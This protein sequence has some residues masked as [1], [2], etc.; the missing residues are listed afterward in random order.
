MGA[1]GLTSLGLD[2][3]DGFDLCDAQLQAVIM[4]ALRAK[5]VWGVWLGTDCSSWSRARRGRGDRNGMPRAMRSGVDLWGLPGLPP[6]EQRT[7]EQ[8]NDMAQFTVSAK[9]CPLS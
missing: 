4:A 3:K 6:S 5:K 8:G 7:V 2:I 9:G 1:A